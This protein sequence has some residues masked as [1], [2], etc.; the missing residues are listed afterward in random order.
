MRGTTGHV[1]AS[2]G[3]SCRRWPRRNPGGPDWGEFLLEGA[4]HWGFCD[5]ECNVV[6][7]TTDRVCNTTIF[8]KRASLCGM[9]GVR[10]GKASVKYLQITATT[11]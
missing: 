4:H 7:V 11:K 5:E 6:I 8:S 3:G 2:G 10:C 1:F 9:R